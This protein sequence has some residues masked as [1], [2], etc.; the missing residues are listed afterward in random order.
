[1]ILD[2]I[3]QEK[4][5]ELQSIKTPASLRE[6]RKK[7]AEVGGNRSF[8]ESLQTKDSINIIAEIKKASP[9]KGII[10]KDFNPIEIAKTYEDNGAAAISV[11]TD[12][13]FFQGDIQYLSEIRKNVSLPLLRK[14]FIIDEFQLYEAKA[15]GADAA[16]LIAAILDKNQLA[17]YLDLSR[18]MGLANLVEVH[19]Y[20]ELEKAMVCEVEIVGI[21]NRNLQTFETSLKTSFELAQDIP[22]DKTIVSE[23]GINNREDILE[24]KKYGVHAFLIG[25]ALMKEKDIGKKLKELL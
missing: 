19:S 4:K 14:D 10:R 6:F 16:L 20:K 21:N 18:E 8:K 15:N 7:A 2:K 22:K 23:S 13:S 24:L 11:L 1:M 3:V 9:S 17:E 25:E 12:K 5:R